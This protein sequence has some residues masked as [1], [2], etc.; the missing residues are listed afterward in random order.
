MAPAQEVTD[1]DLDSAAW[2]RRRRWPYNRALIIAGLAAFACY[3]AV[4]EV[5]CRAVPE[6]EITLF[7]IAFQGVAYLA[8]MGVANLCFNL[9]RW[10]ESLLKPSRPE[11]YRKIAYGLGLWFS[12]ALPFAVPVATW[13]GCGE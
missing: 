13:F 8:A 10:S 11:R 4:F 2:W 3:A 9:G 12:V 1:A 7:T 5:R 6:A